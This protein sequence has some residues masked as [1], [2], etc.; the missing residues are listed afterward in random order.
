MTRR[1]VGI[2]G[3]AKAILFKH[4]HILQDAA[5]FRRRQFQ[6]HGGNELLFVHY[7]CRTE[8]FKVVLLVA[9]MLVE[10]PQMIIATF[11]ENES[12]I[13]LPNHLKV[14]KIFLGQAD[15]IVVVG[16]IGVIGLACISRC[17]C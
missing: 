11:G 7:S 13:E 10:N 1:L 16:S 4:L 8:A 12:E 6:G 17:F 3:K 2:V 15:D 5:L 9:G 14:T